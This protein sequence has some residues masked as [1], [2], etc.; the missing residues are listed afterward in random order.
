MKYTTATKTLSNGIEI[1]Y[2]DIPGITTF[3]LAIG[4]NSG[5]RLANNDNPDLY[6]LP[7]ILE[8]MVFDG[9][10]NYPDYDSLEEVFTTGGGE[11]N[12]A[13]NAYINLFP[14][15][16]RAKY[17]E[18]LLDAALDCVFYPKLTKKSFHEEM[19]VIANELDQ[20]YSDFA[21]NAGAMAQELI[22]PDFVTN[23]DMQVSRLQYITL[24][25]VKKYHT[26]YYTPNNTRIIIAADFR[27]I[28]KTSIERQILKTTADA[29][30]GKRYT[31]P[32]FT[33]ADYE[34]DAIAERVHG[35]Q[36]SKGIEETIANLQFYVTGEPDLKKQCELQ[37]FTALV[38]GMKSYS[39]N[40]KLRKKGLIYDLNL[41][42]MQ[43][44]EG[45]GLE[46]SITARNDKFSEVSA[47]ILALLRD[48]VAEG[49]TEKQFE[50]AKQ[51]FIDGFDD[52]EA[53]VDGI[54]GWYS[55]N[56]LLDDPF[57]TVKDRQ[58]MFTK[59][60]QAEMKQSVSAL[61][62][63]DTLYAAIFSQNPSKAAKVV[64]SLNT[65]IL[66]EQKNVDDT[67]IKKQAITI[68]W[69]NSWIHK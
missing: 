28:K 35:E 39:V 10:R 50:A 65:H 20:G 34:P 15:H 13:T 69:I 54:I 37:L 43:S 11:W 32:A 48:F 30:V 68:G 1:M 51:E 53:S 58:Q 52:A 9:S 64:A 14:F 7:H 62:R 8:H 24:E 26:K 23:T 55:M 67:F 47:N 45:Y 40:H 38:G 4:I 36:I 6:E 44:V 12:G 60:T 3:D 18:A 57:V 19:D 22:I 5:Y 17:A 63:F 56:F 27:A 2:L 29:P 49:I 31:Y 66:K 25:A 21:G 59:L 42:M 33:V 16:N 46:L 41:D 61:L